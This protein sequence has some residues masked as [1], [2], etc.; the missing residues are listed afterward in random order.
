MNELVSIFQKYSLDKLYNKYDNLYVDLLKDVKNS[1]NKLLEVGIGT[2]DENLLSS[3]HYYQQNVAPNYVH[4]NSLRAWRDYFTNAQI[5][6]IDVDDK[7]M[8]TEDRIKTF[9]S[10]SM[11]K[12][13]MTKIM[14][15]IGNVDIII[16]DGLHKME[17]NITTLE[18]LFPFLN[19]GGI[20]VIEDINQFEDWYIDDMLKDERFLNI[21]NGHKFDVHSGFNSYYT[22]VIVIKK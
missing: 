10:N 20:Y 4:G 5:Y 15:I 17:A 13:N 14:D 8:F 18:I 1:T 7:T 12:D 21:V 9:C 16:E 2:T 6:G 22:R 19:E 11:D 3:M